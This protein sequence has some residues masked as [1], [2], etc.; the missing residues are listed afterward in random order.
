MSET[1]V[2]RGLRC[3]AFV[4]ALIAATAGAQDTCDV[5]VQLDDSGPFPIVAFAVTYGGAEGDFGVK[6]GADGLVPDLLGASTGT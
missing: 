3:L 1:A 2:G 4:A 6:E 5:T